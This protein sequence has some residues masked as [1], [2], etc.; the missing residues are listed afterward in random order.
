M[1]RKTLFLCLILTFAI[2]LSA[3]ACKNSNEETVET[4]ITKEPM[5]AQTTEPVEPP[6]PEETEKDPWVTQNRVIPDVISEFDETAYQ[7]LS[8]QE[9]LEQHGY[10]YKYKPHIETLTI[11]NT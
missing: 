8:P 3:T 5:P 1:K 10:F 7:V 4:T 11:G 2:L 9:A 6:I